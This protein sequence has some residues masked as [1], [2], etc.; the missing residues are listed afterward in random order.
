VIVPRQVE[1][2]LVPVAASA[3][4]I[5][6]STL[7]MEPCWMALGQAAGVAAALCVR[8]GGTPRGVSRAKL[9]GELLRQEA[10]LIYFRDLTPEHPH[11]AAL[12]SAGLL[13]WLAAWEAKPDQPVTADQA[14]DWIRRAGIKTPPKYEPG[15][16]TRG[17]FLSRLLEASGHK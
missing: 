15:Q 2:L 16:T 6:F 3:T 1:G 4:H 14:A 8:D 17:E 12:Q 13:G 10:V 7:R 9:Q 5:G 11:F